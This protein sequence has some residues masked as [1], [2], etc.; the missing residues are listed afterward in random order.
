MAY[1]PT[2]KIECHGIPVDETS[3]DQDN[4]TVDAD[5]RLPLVLDELNSQSP[6]PR[7]INAIAD[8]QKAHRWMVTMV[9]RQTGAEELL[10]IV[11]AG[12]SFKDMAQEVRRH[13]NYDWE[14][15]EWFDPE[16]PF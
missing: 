4:F 10:D 5:Q 11:C 2:Q 16:V 15:F 8:A 13:F 12:D 6:N 14:I 9:N 3:Y 1:G 7:Y